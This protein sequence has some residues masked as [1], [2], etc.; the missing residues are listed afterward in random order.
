MLLFLMLPAERLSPAK[1]LIMARSLSTFQ[2]CALRTE[3]STEPNQT[4]QLRSR[5]TLICV[6]FSLYINLCHILVH[7][8]VSWGFGLYIIS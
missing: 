4:Q 7:G 1:T 6:M 8:S 2:C 3:L 5:Y